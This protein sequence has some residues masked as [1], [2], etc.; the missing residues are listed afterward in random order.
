MV[1]FRVSSENRNV[2]QKQI[3]TVVAVLEDWAQAM[4]NGTVQHRLPD[5]SIVP[6]PERPPIAETLIEEF[7]E[8]LDREIDIDAFSHPAQSNGS[9]VSSKFHWLAYPQRVALVQQLMR[10]FVTH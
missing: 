1:D 8:E 3:D 7:I 6:L 10:V 5:P 2:A 4:E 9:C